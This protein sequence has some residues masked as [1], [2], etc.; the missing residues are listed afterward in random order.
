MCDELLAGPA[1]EQLILTSST[2][3]YF[4]KSFFKIL[5]SIMA[6]NAVKSITSTNELMMESQW[7][8]NVV[9]R[10]VESAYLFILLTY[11]I[12]GVWTHSTAKEKFI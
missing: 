4:E 11:F 7:I 9:G 12:S 8:S 6:R 2:S 1:F 5:I 10:K 3:I